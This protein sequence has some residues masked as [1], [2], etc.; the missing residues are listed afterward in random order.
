[1]AQFS[2]ILG[3]RAS[4]CATLVKTEPLGWREGEF[5]V[6]Y[7]IS[8]LWGLVALF[9]AQ[10]AA[11]QVTFNVG[12]SQSNITPG[13]TV[14]VNHTINNSVGVAIG[15]F[16]FNTSS[17]TGAVSFATPSNISS[18]CGGTNS[19]NASNISFNGFTVPATSSC[20]L[21]YD[22]TG[23]GAGSFTQSAIT[24]NLGSGR[25]TTS[26]SATLTVA[27]PVAPTVTNQLVGSSSAVP[28]L[29]ENIAFVYRVRVNNTNPATALTG[30]AFTATIQ[31]GLTENAVPEFFNCSGTATPSTT[32]GTLSYAV[33][34]LSVNAGTLCRVEFKLQG[35]TGGS[36]V[37][38]S[39]DALTSNLPDA[40]PTSATQD[41][42]FAPT[43]VASLSPSPI[44]LDGTTT[45]SVTL[46]NPNTTTALSDIEA[47]LLNDASAAVGKFLVATPN[48]V[49]NGCGSGTVDANAGTDVFNIANISLPAG[50]S[51]TIS[52]NVV[53]DSSSIPSSAVAVGPGRQEIR[54]PVAGTG[55]TNGVFVGIYQA[56]EPDF[57]LG[58]TPNPV[59]AGQ[60]VTLVYTITNNDAA[61]AM[62]GVGFTH[63]LPAGIELDT[64]IPVGLSGCTGSDLTTTSS[65]L[66]LEDVTV[67]TSS[68]CVVTATITPTTGGSFDLEPTGFTASFGGNI[69]EPSVTLVSEIA[70]V[71]SV[72]ASRNNVGIGEVINLV[73]TLNNS[74]NSSAAFGA[75][76]SGTLPAGLE[77]D[78]SAGAAST[79]CASTT[80]VMANDGANSFSYS[81][82]GV[83]D[84]ASCTITI[85][86]SGTSAGNY[87]VTSGELTTVP[88]GSS[89]TATANLTIVPPLTFAAAFSPNR[90][91]GGATSR[92]TFTI[93][94][95]GSATASNVNFTGDWLDGDGIDFSPMQNLTS[96]G[97]GAGA[98]VTTGLVATVLNRVSLSNGQI[99]PGGTCTIGVNV[100]EENG[101]PATVV[102]TTSALTSSVG[103]TAATSATVEIDTSAPMLNAATILS[104]NAV[105]TM[106][107]VGDIITLSLEFDEAMDPGMTVAIG[108]AA[109]TV[110]G[111]SGSDRIFDATV[112]VDSS[113]SVGAVPFS[114]T[115]LEDA[116]GNAL[117][118]ISATTDGSSVTIEGDGPVARVVSIASDNADPTLA[119]IG[120]TITLSLEFDEDLAAA[121]SVEIAGTAAAVTQ[122]SAS[123]YTATVTVDNTFTNG[124]ATILVS[125]ISDGLGNSAPDVTA[126]TDGSMVTVRIGPSA[127]ETQRQIVSFMANR[128]QAIV[129]NTPDFI[130]HVNGGAVGVAMNASTTD[131]VQTLDLSVSRSAILAFSGDSIGDNG[132]DV[133]AKIKGAKS[134]SGTASGDFWLGQFGLHKFINDQTII[135]VMAQ[136]DYAEETDSAVGSFADGTGWMVGPYVAGRIGDQN[137]YYQAM[138]TY[139]QSKNDIAPDGTYVDQFDTTRMMASAKLQGSFATGELTISPALQLS[140][141]TETQKA[142]VDTNSVAIP[143][144]K[145]SFG[146]LSFGPTISRQITGANGA[147]MVPSVGIS[148]VYNFDVSDNLS[149]QGHTLGTNDFRARLNAGLAMQLASGA[150][151][152]IEGYYDGIGASGFESYGLSFDV[153]VPF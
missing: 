90:I 48:G 137:L 56:L 95:P 29:P 140:Y 68:S 108:G 132:W 145:I 31:T 10:I 33:T 20:T 102:M 103:T 98:S 26:N 89:G 28:Q 141:F 80:S 32:G 139:G 117:G 74:A 133:W 116:A 93:T 94:N 63:N 19:Q 49:M 55:F 22:L 149:A 75:S 104:N 13:Q 77:I 2:C 144:T 46:T 15:P 79:T 5:R 134:E 53:L 85:P 42:L 107:T 87:T 73:Y 120:D 12:F 151:V 61:T 150:R 105:T 72:A 97:C 135:G 127:E 125:A 66:A 41:V 83:G 130:S 30:G 82:F 70:P 3:A 92:L 57:T 44:G 38:N 11:A 115:A 123:Q 114:V 88:Y 40:T 51:C 146:E 119:R 60:N 43:G 126:S 124:D 39:V 71:L 142:Y 34:G 113:F 129:G 106:A 52:T 36:T 4:R 128:A 25:S 7:F 21:S 45:Y 131:G 18:T 91:A 121:P 9:L 152:N 62:T 64:T 122:A 99:A 65:S 138:L 109:A 153:N 35:A 59:V 143:E 96:I 78:T 147:V 69:P 14:T 37:T 6:K 100:V 50:G 101:V 16:S 118:D 111:R 47:D 27:P 148:G 24:L 110:V 1:M 76:F 84:G 23:I 17:I 67:G 54:S 112:T 81:G 8:F 136:I 58:A 86:V